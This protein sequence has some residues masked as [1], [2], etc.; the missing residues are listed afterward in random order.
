MHT[1]LSSSITPHMAVAIFLSHEDATELKTVLARGL[2]TYP[3]EKGLEIQSL[4]DNLELALAP[5]TPPTNPR[6]KARCPNGWG[7][8]QR[9]PGSKLPDRASSDLL[10]LVSNYDYWHLAGTPDI[11][12]SR[13]L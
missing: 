1:I 9:I 7:Y 6:S 3:P 11:L 4:L 5:L 13:P 12:E 2:N 8:I 10:S